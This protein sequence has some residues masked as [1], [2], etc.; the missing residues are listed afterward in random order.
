MVYKLLYSIVPNQEVAELNSEGPLRTI[1]NVRIT[2]HIIYPLNVPRNMKVAFL[3]AVGALVGATLATPMNGSPGAIFKR[4]EPSCNT[5]HNN[6]VPV[7][8][9][10]NAVLKYL[11]SDAPIKI[12]GGSQIVACKPTCQISIWQKEAGEIKHK[13]VWKTLKS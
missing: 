7:D 6:K 9:D 12:E 13:T 10:C 3:P 11:D 4:G 8:N 1:R 5:S 2:L